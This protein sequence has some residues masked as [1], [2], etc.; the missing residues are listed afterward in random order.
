MNARRNPPTKQTNKKIINNPNITRTTQRMITVVAKH[1]I[2]NAPYFYN[3]NHF[4]V[5]YNGN[6][7]DVKGR[8]LGA[9]VWELIY[10]PD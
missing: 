4:D 7:S 2:L 6:H 1:V 10:E 3:G 8:S 5:I 9:G